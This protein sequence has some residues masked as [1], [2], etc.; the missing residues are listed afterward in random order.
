MG[1]LELRFDLQEEILNQAGIDL[2][3]ALSKPPQTVLELALKLKVREMQLKY[4]NQI[5]IAAIIFGL[6]ALVAIFTIFYQGQ[7]KTNADSIRQDMVDLIGR[8]YKGDPEAHAQVLRE[9]PVLTTG[10]LKRTLSTPEATLDF[11]SPPARNSDSSEVAQVDDR[12]QS[13]AIQTVAVTTPAAEINDAPATVQAPLV[14]E[15]ALFSAAKDNSP[16]LGTI[17][18]DAE[19]SYIDR[20]DVWS[21]VMLST[22]VPVWASAKYVNDLGDNIGKV[23]VDGLRIRSLP[24]LGNDLV[25]GSINQGDL[26]QIL[27]RRDD[28]VRIF[29]P[30]DYRAWVKTAELDQ[31]L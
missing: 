10:R 28:W 11:V 25:V 4:R 29:S 27:E 24:E 26:V 23:T 20:G 22:G 21:S 16:I 5:I 7:S 1:N 9:M 15:V 19:I 31:L 30:A 3:D 18:T 6:L 12:P 2:E 14:S 13:R 8:A 17:K